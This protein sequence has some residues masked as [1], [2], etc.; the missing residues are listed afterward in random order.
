MLETEKE[1]GREK[2]QELSRR[3]QEQTK[4]KYERNL[5]S[6]LFGPNGTSGYKMK[7]G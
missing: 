1:E 5:H 2:E 6:Y 7:T 3:K 4:A